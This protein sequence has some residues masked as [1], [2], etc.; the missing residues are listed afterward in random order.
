MNVAEHNHIQHHLPPER[1]GAIRDVVPIS[2]GLSG[3]GVYSVTTETGDYVLRILPPHE[4][5]IW[6]RQL[7]VLRL[8]SE[9][10]IAPSLEHVDEAGRATISTRIAGPPFGAALSDPVA[11]GRAIGSLVQQIARLHR[12]SID[13]YDRLHPAEVALAL[14]RAQSAR[15]GFPRWAM[16]FGEALERC[17]GLV[18]NDPRWV[19]SH[20]DLN[21]GNVLWDGT[22]VWLVDW[23]A[24]GMTHPYYDL[25]TITMFLQI[26]DAG[27]LALLAEQE[28]TTPTAE[29]GE[30][31]RALR[32]VAAILSGLMIL[33]LTSDDALHAPEHIADAPTLGECYAKMRSGALDLQSEAGRC[34]F[35]LALLRSASS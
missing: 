21:P 12:L 5:D 29:Q 11:R 13:G 2:V 9:H 28:G 19:L 31:F 25:A 24:S 15:S 3:A 10:G 1:F 18:A 23:T 22:R 6:L 20:N 32:R 17:A 30:T 7:A 35:G 16:S 27:A 14:W 8:T 4:F 33:K 34:M 26:S